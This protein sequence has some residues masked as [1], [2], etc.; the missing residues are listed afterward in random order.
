M[1]GAEAKL[2]LHCS[3]LQ[4]VTQGMS[5]SLISLGWLGEP[6]PPTAGGDGLTCWEA[7]GEEEAGSAGAGGHQE[8]GHE[9]PL[10]QL[11]VDI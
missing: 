2:R 9:L 1:P 7:Q 6:R 8:M 4:R 11:L 3:G 5:A 10:V